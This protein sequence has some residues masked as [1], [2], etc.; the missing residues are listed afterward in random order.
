[1]DASVALTGGALLGN[2]MRYCN[3]GIPVLIEAPLL[4][5]EPNGVRNDKDTPF[6]PRFKPRPPNKLMRFENLQPIIIILLVVLYGEVLA[7]STKYS[8]IKEATLK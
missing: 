5:M 6:L 1:M 4:P 8:I 3:P 2:G 7:Q